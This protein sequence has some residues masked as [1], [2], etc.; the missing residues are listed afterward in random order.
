MLLKAHSSGVAM[1]EYLCHDE[2]AKAFCKSYWPKKY[3]E[4]STSENGS[5][6]CFLLQV[7]VHASSLNCS[8]EPPQANSQT[9]CSVFVFDEKMRSESTLYTMQTTA[10]PPQVLLLVANKL[11]IQPVQMNE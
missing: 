7:R 9:S 11:E 6:F 3:V 2:R 4:S 10:V 1:L 5:F 8:F